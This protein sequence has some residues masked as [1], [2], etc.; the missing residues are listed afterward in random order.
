MNSGTNIDVRAVD[1]RSAALPAFDVVVANLTGGLLIQ[2]AAR[3]QGLVRPAGLLILSGFMKHEEADVLTALKWGRRSFKEDTHL[4]AEE[5]EW[6]CVTI[7][8]S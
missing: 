1:F 2:A 6:L 4:R 5:D 3:L 7:R 8:D